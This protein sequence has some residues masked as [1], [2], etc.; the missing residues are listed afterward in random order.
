MPD[1]VK[2]PGC[3][4]IFEPSKH[5]HEPKEGESIY[6]EENQASGDDLVGNALRRARQQAEL[7]GCSVNEISRV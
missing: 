4:V 3:G 2:C 1:Y 5:K 7:K 6:K